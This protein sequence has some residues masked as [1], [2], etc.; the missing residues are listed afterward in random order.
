LEKV[1]QQANL[2]ARE[3]L[4]TEHQMGRS[5]GKNDEYSGGSKDQ[6]DPVQ[7]QE[8][9]EEEDGDFES[10]KGRGA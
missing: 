3:R 8:A 5:Q 2:E 1:Q 9:Q 4:E 10:W 7:Y 6:E